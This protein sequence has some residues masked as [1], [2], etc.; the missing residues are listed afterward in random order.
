MHSRHDG[1]E[2]AIH[3]GKEDKRNCSLGPVGRGGGSTKGRDQATHTCPGGLPPAVPA[4][5]QHHEGTGK[6]EGGQRT[7]D[8][9]P[10][11][12][13]PRTRDIT[14]RGDPLYPELWPKV[15]TEPNFYGR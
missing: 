15:R 6:A 10:G 1:R 12:R 7:L 5:Q 14:V 9:P 3:S 8:P 2:E 11:P 4:L 13:A